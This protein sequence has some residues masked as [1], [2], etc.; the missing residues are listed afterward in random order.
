MPKSWKVKSTKPKLTSLVYFATELS[1]VTFKNKKTTGKGK[2]NS[3]LLLLI[4]ET[5]KKTGMVQRSDPFRLTIGLPSFSQ[6]YSG[7][8]TLFPVLQGKE[9]QFLI[10]SFQEC[11]WHVERMGWRTREQTSVC[12]RAPLLENPLWLTRGSFQFGVSLSMAS[13]S[14]SKSLGLDITFFMLNL[15]CF[16]LF[17]LPWFNILMGF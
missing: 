4:E 1:L 2:I 9:T 15:L 13:G 7:S 17:N 11:T 14:H 16:L 10:L 3:Q 5:E 12:F 8:I 6:T